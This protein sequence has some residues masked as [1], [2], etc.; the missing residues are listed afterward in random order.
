MS[1]A[2]TWPKVRPPLDAEQQRIME[3]WYG[4]YLGNVLPNRFGAIDRFGHE[5]VL[6]S[7][8]DGA[9]TL[10]VGPGTGSHLQFE[11]LK[12]HE[13]YVG[14]ELRAT[15]G[16]TIER[17]Y[18]GVRLVVGDCQQRID[19]PDHTF[20]RVIAIHVLEHLDN[21][22]AALAE[23]RRVLKPSGR[24]SIVIPCEGG[25]GYAMGR[26]VTTKRLFEKRYK[27]PYEPFIRHDHVNTAR[28][29]LAAL[30]R[31]FRTVHRTFYPLRVPSVDANLVIGLT[32][33]PRGQE[34]RA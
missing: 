27:V 26:A 24:L 4:H 17:D 14:V 31:D 23:F 18:P 7:M 28:D 32:L 1:V 2:P 21:L 20:D 3:D 29:V 5:Y 8:V 22:P 25:A 16:N 9:R 10:E 34:E 15:L 11:D 19:F 13:Q 12:R 30:D 6:R 33:A